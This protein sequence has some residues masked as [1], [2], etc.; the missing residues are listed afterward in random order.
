MCNDKIIHGVTVVL[1][2]NNEF[3]RILFFEIFK[4]HLY[5][6]IILFKIKKYLV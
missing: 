1:R 2:F 5:S 6:L 3:I 4:Y